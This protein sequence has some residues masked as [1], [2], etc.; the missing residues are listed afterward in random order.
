MHNVISITPLENGGKSIAIGSGALIAGLALISA[1]T[2]VV[3]IC[4]NATVKSRKDYTKTLED[5]TKILEERVK[6]LEDRCYS[7]PQQAE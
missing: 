4:K 5:Y 6:F 3:K 1:T 2:A 7:K